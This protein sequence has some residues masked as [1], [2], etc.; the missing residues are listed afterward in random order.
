[1]SGAGAPVD[2]YFDFSSPYGYIA[3]EIAEG[4]EQRIGRPVRWRPILLGAVFKITGQPPLVDVPMKG[5][6]SRK[7]FAR[8]ARLHKVPYRQP[9]K[10]PIFT[11]APMRAFY[12]MQD[13]DPAKARALAKAL[14]RA[15][16]AD[17]RDIG[18]PATVI[19]VAKSI[20]IDGAALAA[21]LEDPAVK[22]RGKREVD[23]AIAAGVFGSPFFVVDGEG[24]WGVDRMPMLERWIATGGW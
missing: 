24:F 18:S 16:F 4:M 10:F 1:M 3:S 2:F 20:G 8:S 13:Q 22:E 12:W 5:E 6:Y 19:E 14:F 21:A 23:A 7:D 11:V 9:G 15:Y 17:D